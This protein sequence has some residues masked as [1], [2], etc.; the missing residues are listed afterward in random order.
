M[1][2][3]P[4]KLLGEVLDLDLD[5]IE[6]NP[7]DQYPVA[8]VYSF[9]RGLFA[10]EAIVGSDTKYK[11]L[12]R[13]HQGQL[14]VSRLKAFEGAVAV[15]PLELDGTF[16]S[17]EF[18][19]F[20][21]NRNGDPNY[22]AH[23][24]R[25]PEFWDL[26]RNSSRGV[27][28]RRERVHADQVLN[29]K[30]PLP[31]LEEQR[32]VAHKL[33]RATTKLY[34]ARMKG[35]RVQKI[36]ESLK[37]S[38]LTHAFSSLWEHYGSVPLIAVAEINPDSINP[39]EWDSANFTYIDIGSVGKG[40]GRIL[41][42]KTIPVEETPSRARRLV[43]RDDVLV[44]TVR[45]NLRGF[46]LVPADLDGAV[47]S[48]GFAVL[49]PHSDLDSEFLLLQAM[50]DPILEQLVGGV[51]GGHYPAVSDRRLRNVKLTQPPIPVQRRVV[52]RLRVQQACVDELLV[53]RR[54][55]LR[56]VDSLEISLLNH[57]FNGE[58]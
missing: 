41:Q 29:I 43:R 35:Q 30:V 17:Q 4:L 56:R 22:V 14:V 2:R 32:R 23:L 55:S 46:A 58:L 8:G 39:G 26:L 24:C 57:A 1:S 45:P 11:T 13:L 48:T 40:S 37:F 50:S 34:L 31:D 16:L 7:L 12:V 44:S 47:C 53:N 20:N 5:Q 49:R 38:I 54:S 9:G 42:P 19:T 36:A 15:V 28:A 18:P 3:Y 6:V 51:R 21:I 10:R 52:S 25:W 27:G 33:D